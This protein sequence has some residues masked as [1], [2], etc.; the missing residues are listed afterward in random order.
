M[1]YMIIHSSIKKSD[2]KGHSM[3]NA[4]TSSVW[5]CDFETCDSKIAILKNEF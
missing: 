5:V 1:A 2:F 4:I 3:R